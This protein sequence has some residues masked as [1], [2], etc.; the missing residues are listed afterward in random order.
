MPDG[1]CMRH[2]C[3]VYTDA[4]VHPL[5]G[6]RV[7]SSRHTAGG[8]AHLAAIHA[9]P[10]VMCADGIPTAA[11]PSG[12]AGVGVEAS[13]L[14]LP[15]RCDDGRGLH[16]RCRM[17]YEGVHLCSLEPLATREK[18]IGEVCGKHPR[19]SLP[20]VAL[21][22]SAREPMR[23]SVHL[24]AS[25]GCCRG[26]PPGTGIPLDL[27]APRTGLPGAVGGGAIGGHPVALL[28][29]AR[30]QHHPN[31]IQALPLLIE[32]RRAGGTGAS[33]CGRLR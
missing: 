3:Q 32:A 1:W 28:P 23:H 13:G 16:E 22:A 5:S 24:G 6:R 14:A 31:R 9:Y 27:F 17:R 19:A 29:S 21:A 26:C 10:M 20:A 11:G 30:A 33:N 2:Y 12:M 4:C 25:R 15:R 8:Q 7:H 18:S